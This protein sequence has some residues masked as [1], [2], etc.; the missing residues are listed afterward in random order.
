MLIIL[1]NR[2]IDSNRFKRLIGDNH[3]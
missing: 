2:K 1:K 3:Y